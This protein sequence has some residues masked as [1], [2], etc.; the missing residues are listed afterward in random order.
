MVAVRMYNKREFYFLVQF[1][2]A[3]VRPLSASLLTMRI[4]C[5]PF[6]Y[7][8]T[9]SSNPARTVRHSYSAAFSDN[10]RYRIPLRTDRPGLRSSRVPAWAS[11]TSSPLSANPRSIP[12]SMLQRSEILVSH[13]RCPRESTTIPQ[14]SISSNKAVLNALPMSGEPTSPCNGTV[15]Y[16]SLISSPM[17]TWV[18]KVGRIALGTCIPCT[19][20]VKLTRCTVP[21]DH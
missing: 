9:L 7:K 14:P 2:C 21:A 11:P 19:K 20:F 8:T 3:F 5:S 6:H 18:C 10:E 4:V 16:R 13:R 15:G 1:Y 17:A 12:R